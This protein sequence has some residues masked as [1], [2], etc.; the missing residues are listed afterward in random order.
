MNARD[1]GKSI[2]RCLRYTETLSAAFSRHDDAAPSIQQRALHAY[3]ESYNVMR[4]DWGRLEARMSSTSNPVVTTACAKAWLSALTEKN[5]FDKVEEILQ[6]ARTRRALHPQPR[7]R[8][9]PG[10][11]P[12]TAWQ[13]EG[14]PSTARVIWVDICAPITNCWA[15]PLEARLC[16]ATGDVRRLPSSSCHNT[17]LTHVAPPMSA[18]QRVPL[19]AAL[20]RIAALR[21]LG[22]RGRTSDERSDR[23]LLRT[24]FH[25]PTIRA[26]CCPPA[27]GPTSTRPHMEVVSKC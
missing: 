19:L 12:G 11:G 9:R 21:A 15:Y 23:H 16:G 18:Y 27:T 7:A 13:T 20:P 14:P 10:T 4:K 25:T 24:P 1:L 17:P 2:E 5:L 26:V 22:D 8:Q 3:T 6:I